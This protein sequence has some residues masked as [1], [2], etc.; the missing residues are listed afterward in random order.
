[1]QLGSFKKI[2]KSQ[3]ILHKPIVFTLCHL[4]IFIYFA[5]YILN[6]FIIYKLQLWILFLIKI[7]EINYLGKNYIIFNN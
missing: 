4:S 3:L 7:F 1:M 2:A 6:N 5:F